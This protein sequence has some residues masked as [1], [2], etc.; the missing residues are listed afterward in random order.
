MPDREGSTILFRS[1]RVEHFSPVV[2][3]AADHPPRKIAMSPSR[4]FAEKRS[5]ECSVLALSPLL[6]HGDAENACPGCGRSQWLVGR[7]TAQCASCDTALPLAHGWRWTD[8][9]TRC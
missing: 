8:Q 6:Y 2:G 3:Y 4:V 9:K 1:S 7:L 5:D